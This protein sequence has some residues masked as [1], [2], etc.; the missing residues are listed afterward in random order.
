MFKNTFQDILI[1]LFNTVEKVNHKEII[2]K[3]F[4]L[5]LNKVQKIN[6]VE[7]CI[8]HQWL[9]GV[10]FALYA[11]NTGPVDGTDIARL[12]VGIIREFF[13]D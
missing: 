12:V 6:S 8:L 13:S 9:Q 2:N 10:F 11:L 4:C 1:I 7:N 5:Y 3:Q